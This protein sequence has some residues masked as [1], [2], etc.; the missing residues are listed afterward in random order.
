MCTAKG[1]A[2][3]FR[4]IRI[5]GP[6]SDIVWRSALEARMSLKCWRKYSLATVGDAVADA[7]IWVHLL[8]N[9][10]HLLRGV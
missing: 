1:V 5:G 6:D 7:G 4:W 3:G 2:P 9:F 8:T 10:P